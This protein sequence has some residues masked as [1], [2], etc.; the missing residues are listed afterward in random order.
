MNIGFGTM[1]G[2]VIGLLLGLILAKLVG[3]LL[4]LSGNG[5]PGSFIIFVTTSL[6]AGLCI[7]AAIT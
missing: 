7:Y 1:I 6:I 3:K 5:I 4:N 2:I